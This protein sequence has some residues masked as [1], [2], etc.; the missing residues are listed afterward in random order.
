VG[1]AV[2]VVLA[3]ARA[4]HLPRDGVVEVADGL[5]VVAA[6]GDRVLVVD[7]PPGIARSLEALRARGVRC[8]DAVVVAGGGRRA[9]GLATALARRCGLP[10]LAPAGAA[11]PGWHAVGPGEQVRVGDL[12][13]VAVDGALRVRAPLES[14]TRAAPLPT[15][16]GLGGGGPPVSGDGPDELAELA[17]QAVAAV[18]AATSGAPVPAGDS[19]GARR[20][21]HVVDAI[22][23]ARPE[24][25]EQ[26]GP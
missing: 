26:E 4:P 3:A 12:S 17:D 6:G 8:V 19:P 20:V 16:A 22:A 15:P 14:G 21:R 13:V 18:V 9:A 23:A 7:G 1:A 25:P 11:H 24:Q 5:E 2:V 10:V